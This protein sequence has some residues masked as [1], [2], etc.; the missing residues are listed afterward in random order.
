MVESLILTVDFSP[1][2]N[3]ALAPL[4]LVV[5]LAFLTVA[6]ELSFTSSAAL[7]P[8]KSELSVLLESPLFLSMVA[9]SEVSVPPP[10]T[11]MAF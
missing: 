7:T 11:R 2:A 5:I 8:E 6:V 3:T 10:V 9:P 1:V 4:A